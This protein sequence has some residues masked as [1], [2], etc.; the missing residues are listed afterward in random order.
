MVSSPIERRE[1]AIT[2]AFRRSIDCLDCTESWLFP[3]RLQLPFR[4]CYY[5]IGVERCA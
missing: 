2:G 3:C 4:R 5:G 1:L